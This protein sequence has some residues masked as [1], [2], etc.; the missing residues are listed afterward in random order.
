MGKAEI[1]NFPDAQKEVLFLLLRWQSLLPVDRNKT[2][3]QAKKK[4]GIR[5]SGHFLQ[6]QMRQAGFLFYFLFPPKTN[7][8]TFFFLPS[9]IWP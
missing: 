3:T 5:F 9:Q 7:E 1:W 4:K 2:V 6:K 8:A